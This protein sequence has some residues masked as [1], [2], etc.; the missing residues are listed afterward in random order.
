MANV[1]K[2]GPSGGEGGTYWSYLPTGSIKKIIVRHVEIF[3]SIVFISENEEG[4]D[5]T[6]G[7]FGGLGGDLQTI[8]ELNAPEEYL[9]S[10]TGTL[11]T[12]NNQYVV[13]SI[14]FITNNQN[15]YGPYGTT[16]GTSFEYS[17]TDKKIVGFFGRCDITNWVN[18]I[19]VY[20]ESTT[21]GDLF[22]PAPAKTIASKV[23][24]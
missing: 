4:L 13:E 10:I 14:S 18:A 1:Q 3:N 19:G 24:N 22:S 15:T 17:V 16:D 20:F 8:I 21:A 6:S 9:T 23:I 11:R 7:R 2:E 12:V 5:E